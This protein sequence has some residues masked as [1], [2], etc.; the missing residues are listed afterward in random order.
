MVSIAACVAAVFQIQSAVNVLG[1][2]L[3]ADGY[4]LRLANQVTLLLGGL[5]AFIYVVFLEGHYRE[6]ARLDVL[7]RRFAVTIA[8][9]LGIVALSL[10]LVEIGLRAIH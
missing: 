10:A 8:I 9:L 3:G 2:A 4:A 5:A 1:A 7:L 6:G